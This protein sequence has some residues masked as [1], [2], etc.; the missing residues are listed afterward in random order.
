M[1]TLTIIPGVAF[2]TFL[3]LVL[4]WEPRWWQK[5]LGAV[6]LVGVLAGVWLFVGVVR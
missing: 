6:M 5:L 2:P 3:A 1:T 4:L